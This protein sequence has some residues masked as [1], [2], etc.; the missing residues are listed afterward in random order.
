MCSSTRTPKLQLTAEQL[1]TGEC[2]ILPKKDTPRPR[3]KEKPQQDSR[4][5]KIVFGIKPHIHQRCSESSN[6]PCTHQD[7]ESYTRTYELLGKQKLGEHKLNLVHTRTQEKLTPQETN[8]DFPM[9]VQESPAEAWVG[10]GLLQ[11]QR[12]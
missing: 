10:G 9:S 3:A 7:P 12:H 2:W 11:G 6:K 1:L 4:R 5:G 8:P